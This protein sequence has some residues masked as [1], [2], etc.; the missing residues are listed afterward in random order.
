MCYGSSAA[1]S[2]GTVY[3]VRVWI[4]R[5]AY[6]ARMSECFGIEYRKRL[7]PMKNGM[8]LRKA[9]DTYTASMRLRHRYQELVSLMM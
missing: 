1:G 5:D 3:S 6:I 9:S 4:V 7:T 2:S 8:E